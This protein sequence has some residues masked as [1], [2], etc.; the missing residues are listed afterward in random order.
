MTAEEPEGGA[1]SYRFLAS[2]TSK[3]TPHFWSY[4][5]TPVFLFFKGPELEGRYDIP[6]LPKGKR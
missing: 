3:E 1:F 4:T 6:F 5:L 2:A